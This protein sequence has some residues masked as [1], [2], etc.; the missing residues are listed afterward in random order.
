MNQKGYIKNDTKPVKLLKFLG[1]YSIYGHS[2]IGN[3]MINNGSQGGSKF[4]DN[5]N[6]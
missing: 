6:Q 5:P 3:M 1:I 2:I 4:P